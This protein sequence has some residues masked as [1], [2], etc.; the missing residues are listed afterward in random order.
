MKTFAGV[1]LAMVFLA[2]APDIYADIKIT[3]NL[4]KEPPVPS[5]LTTT[6]DENDVIKKVYF[7]TFL[8]F[9][10]I[11]FDLD[12]DGILDYITARLVTGFEDAFNKREMFDKNAP[13][14]KFGE[15]SEP[16]IDDIVYYTSPYPIFYWYK[17]KESETFQQWI[18]QEED[19]VN[20]NELRYDVYN[21]DF[22]LP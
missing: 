6:G 16:I 1:L 22:P 5:I 7:N 18:D 4:P 10:Y 2:I 9:L 17:S 19:G 20:G 8:R 21:Y 11:E 3:H 12:G 13:L 15:Q 14:D